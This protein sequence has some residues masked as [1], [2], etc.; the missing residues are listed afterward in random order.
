MSAL[1]TCTKC[2]AQKPIELFGKK[3]AAPDGLSRWC[4]QCFADSSKQWRK[5]NPEKRKEHHRKDREKNAD[6]YLNYAR[7]YHNTNRDE[8]NAKRRQRRLDNIEDERATSVEWGRKN[9]DKKRSINRTHYQNNK[10]KYRQWALVAQN[11]RRCA[12]INAT[13]AWTDHNKIADIYTEAHRLGLHVDHIVPLVSEL[14]CGLHTHQNLQ[15]LTPEENRSK[16]NRWWP[17]E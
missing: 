3:S 6:Y 9:K 1:R 8:L 5:N 4:K 12:K 14:V 2:H 13:P 10:E 11:K 17:D 7:E 16:G 15:M